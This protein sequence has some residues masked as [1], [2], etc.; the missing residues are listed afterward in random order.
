MFHYRLGVC[1][2]RWHYGTIACWAQQPGVFPPIFHTVALWL[3]SIRVNHLCLLVSPFWLQKTGDWGRSLPACFSLHLWCQSLR[4]CIIPYSVSIWS[5][6]RW[7]YCV[8]SLQLFST[9]LL[10]YGDPV[11][12][13]PIWCIGQSLAN[14]IS[15]KKTP[16]VIQTSWFAGLLYLPTPVL[17]T[18]NLS[19]MWSL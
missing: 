12:S 9:L 18:L 19:L 13:L 3:F 15:A 4:A 17:L 8:L 16:K 10:F 7:P 5:S 11:S 1:S 2:A 6:D 14:P